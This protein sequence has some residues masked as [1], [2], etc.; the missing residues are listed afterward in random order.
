LLKIIPQDLLLLWR[1]VKDH[2]D[3][4]VIVQDSAFH[5]LYEVLIVRSLIILQSF[6]V[7]IKQLKLVWDVITVGLIAL[8]L[9]LPALREFNELSLLIFPG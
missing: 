3:I 2:I 7:F 5:E 8:Q 6:K 4:L 9:N 1:P